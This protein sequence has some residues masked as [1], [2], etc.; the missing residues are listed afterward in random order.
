[1]AAAIF[2]LYVRAALRLVPIRRKHPGAELDVA[3]QVEPV[4]DVTSLMQRSVSG[5]PAKCSDQVHPSSNSCENDLAEEQLSE[6][7][8][9]TG[10]WFQYHVPPFLV[11]ASIALTRKRGSRRW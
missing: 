4:G 10:Q 8:R 7:T 11:P 5:W 6:S 3:S 1:V 2:R 9:A